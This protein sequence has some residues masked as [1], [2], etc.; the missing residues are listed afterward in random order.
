MV[1]NMRV[2]RDSKIADVDLLQP[3]E[4]VA[5]CAEH[6]L[7][8]AADPARRLD[9]AAWQQ[10]QAYSSQHQGL[11]LIVLIDGQVVGEAYRPGTGP[12]T[13]TQSQSMHKSIVGLAYGAALRDGLVKSLDEPVSNYLD[14][15][16]GDARGRLPLRAF[17]TM[18]S[19]LRNF[20]V[21]KQEPLGMQLIFSDA[22]DAAAL[23]TPVD[24]QAPP[25]AYKNVDAQ[26]AGMALE[27]AIARGTGLRYA[28]W[29]SKTLWCPLGNA[30][31]SVWLERDGGSP[32][33]FADLQAGLRDWARVGQMIADGGRVGARQVLPA[34]WLAEA[35]APSPAN[36]QYGYLM[37]RGS[38]WKAQ[39]GYNPQTAVTIPHS[40]PYAVDDLVF[41]DGFGGQRVY[42]SPSR[43]LVIARTGETDMSL[44]DAIL[45]NLALAGMRGQARP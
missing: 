15:W 16:R 25:F 43:H 1:R 2:Y 20:S 26:I 42:V 29:L 45:P 22:I 8:V 34:A 27:R 11:G 30:N 7:P 12:L 28:Q 9:P 40:A 23:A 41:F 10:M 13:R 17:L 39:R 44:D 32:R 24:A 36:P 35:G 6:A 19:P 38:P 5:G 33:F 31:A 37:W 21:F 14:E 18:S 3:A 4:A